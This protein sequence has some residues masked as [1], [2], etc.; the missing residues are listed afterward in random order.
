MQIH[1]DRYIYICGYW[2][3]IAV[4]KGA[5]RMVLLWGLICKL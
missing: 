1:I 2:K 3:R 5:L 4:S